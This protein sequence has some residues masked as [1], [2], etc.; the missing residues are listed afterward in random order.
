MAAG[1]ADGVN[2]EVT[3]LGGEVVQ[4]VGG[5]GTKVGGLVDVVE[6]RHGFQG[7]LCAHIQAH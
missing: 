3:D 5:K 2:D 6:N 1:L 7:Y 4:L